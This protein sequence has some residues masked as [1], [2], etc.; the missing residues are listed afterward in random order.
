MECREWKIGLGRGFVL[1]NRNPARGARYWSGVD[2][3]GA[4]H[5]YSLLDEVKAVVV[6]V[7]RQEWKIGRGRGFALPNRK[8]SA[9]RSVSV[10]CEWC[11]CRSCIGTTG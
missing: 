8:S 2:A 10:V 7:E 4:D 1:P 9:S 3:V 6:A 5:V 11:W